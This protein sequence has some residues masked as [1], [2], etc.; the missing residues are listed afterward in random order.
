MTDLL[1]ITKMKNGSMEAFSEFVEKYYDA[2]KYYCYA[3]CMDER[4]AEDITQETFLRF[5]ENLSNYEHRGKA[6]NFLY[7]M[8][9]NLI[10]NGIRQKREV[11]MDDETLTDFP[12][13]RREDTEEESVEKMY[14]E[15][16][17]QY[18]TPPC[19]EVVEL[20]YFRGFR[21]EEISRR[22]GIGVPL[23]KYR[24]RRAR[25]I[26]KEKMQDEK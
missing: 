14:C 4:D 21:L 16:M 7:T 6:K 22:L 25:R 24:L 23:V 3:R 11:A 10:R 1:L 19:R 8:A 9:G 13:L 15:E 17:L 26:I 12:E 18:L 5:F 20:F 2:V